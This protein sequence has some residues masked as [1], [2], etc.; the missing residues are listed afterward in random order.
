MN[1]DDLPRSE[2]EDPGEEFRHLLLG[3]ASAAIL[4]AAAFMMA[5]AKPFPARWM[6]IG[7]GALALVQIAAQ[8]RFFLHVDLKKSHRDDLQLVLF[9]GLVIALMVGGSIW[10]LFNQH[11]RMG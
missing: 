3:L 4:T 7:L 11:A 5:V 6:L 8:F 1:D 9:A 2:R 10:I